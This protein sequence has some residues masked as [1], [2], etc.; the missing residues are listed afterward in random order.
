MNRKKRE[1]YKS[2]LL[3]LKENIK[4]GIK[5]IERDNLYKSQREFSGDLSDYPLH[6]ADVGT[7]AN[8]RQKEL[9]IMYTEERLVEEIE[10]ALHR[11]E[12]GG[13]GFCEQCGKEIQKERLDAKPYGR[14]CI[15]C[16][17]KEEGEK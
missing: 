4:R 15:E 5:H 8:D 3:R 10:E 2:L 11:I 17:R 14:L 6:I 9:E 16:K 12:N 1:Y 7:D 13:Y